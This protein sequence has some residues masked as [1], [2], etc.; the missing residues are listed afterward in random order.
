MPGYS[1]ATWHSGLTYEQTCI[2]C[3]TKFTYNDYSLGFRPWFADGFV[4]CPS[5]RKPLRHNENY[6]IKIIDKNDGK[7]KKVKDDTQIYC[8]NCGEIIKKSLKF[9]PNCGVKSNNN[10]ME[11]FKKNGRVIKPEDT[12]INSKIINKE[13]SEEHKVT[14]DKIKNTIDTI[15]KVKNNDKG[16]GNNI[17][18]NNEDSSKTKMKDKKFYDGEV[19]KCPNC[20][21]ILDSFQIKCKSCGYELRGT[22]SNLSIYELNE[23]LSKTA[24]TAT[25]I[26]LITNFYIPN[27]KE[28]I[29]EFFILAISNINNDESCAEAWEAKL[30]QAYH[31]ANLLLANT[32]EFEYLDSLYKKTMEQKRKRKIKKIIL[33]VGLPVGLP[34]LCVLAIILIIIFS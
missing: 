17:K 12:I 2:Q 28:D 20:G 27:T 16:T 30:E 9:C 7:E 29:Y 8:H 26:S 19:H 13:E 1:R 3:K 14:K 4:Y 5:C 32:P 25:K 15:I 34:I 33:N 6:A 22:S 18:D 23:K 21:E 11:T 31:K 10:E 24:N